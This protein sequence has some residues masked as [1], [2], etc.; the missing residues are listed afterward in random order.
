VLAIDE[1]AV[2]T[3]GAIRVRNLAAEKTVLLSGF[4][5]QGEVAADQALWRGL[6]L[7]DNQ[8]AVRVQ[9]CLFS[10][11]QGLEA[12]L[13]QDSADVVLTG[14]WMRG[15]MTG[16]EATRAMYVAD[17]TLAL[18]Q[19]IIDGGDAV[20]YVD[21]GMGAYVTRSFLYMSGC[22]VRGGWGLDATCSSD[23]TDGGDGL[24]LSG[25]TTAY[26]QASTIVGGLG[27]LE[28]LLCLGAGG[29]DGADFLQLN[30]SSLTF[31]TST[32]T[33]LRLR[34]SVSQ[35]VNTPAVAY[36]GGLVALRVQ[37][38]PDESV[39]LVTGRRTAFSYRASYESVRCVARANQPGAGASGA[40]FGPLLGQNGSIRMPVDLG[41][42]PG[43]GE[44]LRSVRIGALD[45]LSATYHL[46]G[47]VEN[48]TGS[49][50]TNP[51]FLVVVP[52]VFAP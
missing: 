32:S 34:P 2:V 28:A 1:D 24:V 15:T 29:D 37:G 52:A 9:D 41:P 39:R 16:S 49:T 14:C 10:K 35:A 5:A 12:V 25:Q 47:V 38:T 7:S 45:G 17:S 4:D 40:A 51:R 21:G 50:L 26:I 11:S 30:G 48:A 3:T 42:I 13:I 8:G 18:F 33:S 46:Q 6:W 36:E 20:E 27:G 23:G 44:I 31:L 19:T 22:S 43:F